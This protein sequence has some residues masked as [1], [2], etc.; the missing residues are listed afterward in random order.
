MNI[1]ETFNEVKKHLL[2]QK[3]ASRNSESRCL[4][5]NADGLKCAIG[6]LIPDEDYDPRLESYLLRDVCKTLGFTQPYAFLERL[7]CIHDGYE[8]ENWERELAKC[9]QDWGLND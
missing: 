4:F 6:I 8:P 9:A 5:R 2:C 3:K 7:Q 1:Q